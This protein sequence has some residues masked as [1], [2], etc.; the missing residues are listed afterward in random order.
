VLAITLVPEF[1][2]VISRGAKALRPGARFAIFDLKRPAGWPESLVRLGAWLN[3]P[4]GVSLELADRHP[5]EA[6]RRNLRQIEFREYYFGSLYLSVG[7][8]GTDGHI[9]T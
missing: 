1:E 2:A 3:S 8:R 5:W 9:A 6:V 7:E 4:Y